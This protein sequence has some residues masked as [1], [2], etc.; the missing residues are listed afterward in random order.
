M[1]MR[2][3]LWT[4]PIV[5]LAMGVP[6][7]RSGDFTLMGSGSAGAQ[8]WTVAGLPTEGHGGPDWNGASSDGHNMNIGYCLA[9]PNCG[10]TSPPGA[11]PYWGNSNG[12]AD[13]NVYFAGNGSS[14]NAALELTIAGNAGIN[15]FGWVQ[16]N[17]SGSSMIGS[18]SGFFSGGT[19]IGTTVTFTPTAYFAFY[20]TG[21]GNTTWY[22]V[23]GQNSTDTNAQHFAFFQ[24]ANS[25]MWIG[26]EDLPVAE[27]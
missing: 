1:N 23:S 16:T 24:G 15:V 13:P 25:T 22:T 6:T 5:F 4:I 27:Q 2:R 18:R 10:L 9:T 19:P 8:T 26:S 21:A 11:L 17:S 3:L 7:A 12:T 20:L 14:G